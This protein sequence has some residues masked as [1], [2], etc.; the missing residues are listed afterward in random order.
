MSLDGVHTTVTDTETLTAAAAAAPQLLEAAACTCSPFSESKHSGK[1]SSSRIILLTATFST[2]LDHKTAVEDR[3]NVARQSP[4]AS[5]HT[6]MPVVKWEEMP[7]EAAAEAPLPAAV[8]AAAALAEPDEL[9]AEAAAAATC[10][11]VTHQRHV[12]AS[13]HDFFMV[14]TLASMHVTGSKNICRAHFQP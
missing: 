12:T 1:C 9:A 10:S 13:H 4:E 14:T 3:S 2:L 8:A 6:L 5:P 11:H 7:T